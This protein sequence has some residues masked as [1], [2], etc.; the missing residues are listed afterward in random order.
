MQ[1]L[2]H[3]TDLPWILQER[4]HTS[5][6]EIAEFCRRWQIFEFAL[7]GSVLRD[8]FC[9]TSDVDVLVTYNPETEQTLNH[10]ILAQTELE[11]LFGRAVDLTQKQSLVNPFSRRA[12]LD[13]HRIIYPLEKAEPITITVTNQTMQD[14][15]RNHAALWDMVQAIQRIQTFTQGLNEAA[16]LENILVQ[17]AVEQNLEIIG[18]AARGRITPEFRTHYP[19]VDWSGVI[20]LRNVVAHQYDQVNHVQIWRMITTILPS[21]QAQLTTLLPSTPN[22]EK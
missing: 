8:D 16:Y 13:Q 18:E 14:S 1:Q 19:E 2:K 17:Q 20:G 12:I 6:L 9:P 7:F 22:T 3:S 10:S 11:S 21:L 15:V 5:L 4:L